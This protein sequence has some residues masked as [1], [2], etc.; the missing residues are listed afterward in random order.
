[1]HAARK[2]AL[3]SV[4]V[5]ALVGA[6]ASAALADPSST[7]PLNSIVGL[8]GDEAQMFDQLAADYDAT[9]PSEPV[10]CWDGVNPITG[11]VGDT[12]IT[13]SS[14]SGDTLCEIA[15]P[16]GGNASITTLELNTMDSGDY[17][18]D[19]VVSA[20]PPVSSDPSTIAFVA[21][22]GGGMTWSSP[23]GISGDSS[24]VPSTLTR[25]DLIDIYTCV[26]TNWDQVGGSNA[27]IVPVLPQSGSGWRTRWLLDL[28][29]TTPGSCVVNGSNSSGEIEANTGLSA[30]NVAQFKSVD[31]IFPYSIGDY[32]AQGPA[33]DGVG[34]HAT[35]IWG[36]GDL[37]L[38]DITNSNGVVEA[39]TTTNSAGQPI[40]NRSFP[41]DFLSALYVVVRNAG[42]ATDPVI[43]LY[44]QPIFGSDG[45]ICTSAIAQA[46][47]VS[48]GFWNLGA[49]CGA[50]T[51]G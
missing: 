28:G 41:P 23:T 16:D 18:V 12:I 44:L 14:G 4:T 47:I 49:S 39:P 7:P 36:H 8:C 24:P 31:D 2:I 13:K 22:A 32:I 3:I 35:S 40:I 51:A 30:A 34:G 42:T 50:V 20:A 26:D 1:M 43:P 27:P 45:W 17:C 9:D 48:Y 15:R 10:Y 38:H 19:F 29:I 21:T 33:T 6:T 46:D 37:E 11:A 25:T 5:A